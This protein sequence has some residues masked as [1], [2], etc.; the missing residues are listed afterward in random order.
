MIA[1]SMR[2]ELT[3]PNADELERFLKGMG[4]LTNDSAPKCQH[5]DHKDHALN[6]GDPGTKLG[7]VVL[8][9]DDHGCAHH[10]AKDD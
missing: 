7:K 4:D 9:S 8:H 2:S 5:T 10:G 1:T 3:D 6:N